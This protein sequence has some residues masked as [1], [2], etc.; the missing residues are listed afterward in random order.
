M[1]HA[2]A[3]GDRESGQTISTVST[4]GRSRAQG[5]RAAQGWGRR[6]HW[7]TATPPGQDAL[8]FCRFPP[9][10]SWRR[11]PPFPSLSFLSPYPKL[12]YKNQL[13]ALRAEPAGPRGDEGR[14][15][16]GGPGR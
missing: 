16:W 5:R 4:T 6:A 9:F 11:R 8:Y 1:T 12:L 13:L 10:F 7:V 3:E 2:V 14:G 15:A